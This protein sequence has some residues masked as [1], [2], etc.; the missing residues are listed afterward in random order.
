MSGLLVISLIICILGLMAFIKKSSDAFT[1]YVN[2]SDNEIN[3]LKLALKDAY[4]EE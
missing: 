3:K 1:E 2:Y 4:V